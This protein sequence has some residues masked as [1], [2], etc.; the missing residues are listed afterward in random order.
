MIEN[1][2]LPFIILRPSIV[3]GSSLNGYVYRMRVLYSAWRIL[4]TGH[5]PRVPMDRQGYVDLVPINFVVTASQALSRNPKAKGKTLHL[6][7]GSDFATSMEVLKVANDAFGLP[8]PSLA[9]LIAGKIICHPLIRVFLPHELLQIVEKM[10]WHLPYLGTKGRIFDVLETTELLK[11]EAITCPR[12]SSYG[13]KL[14][15]F[16]RRSSWGKVGYVLNRN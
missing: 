5:L 1:S 3:V 13:R 8:M 12:F 9:P 14:F 4:L 10:R 11:G 7:A 15:E 6:C 16:C 2:G